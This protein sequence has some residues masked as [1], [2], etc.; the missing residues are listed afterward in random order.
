M[1]LLRVADRPDRVE[2]FVEVA[3]SGGCAQHVARREREEHLHRVLPFRSIVELR[4]ELQFHHYVGIDPEHQHRRRGDAEVANVEAVLLHVPRASARSAFPP[5]PFPEAVAEH[6]GIRSIRRVRTARRTD[7][8]HRVEIQRDQ[9]MSACVD[10]AQ[11]FGV[12]EPVPRRSRSSAISRGR[13]CVL[14]RLE[15][16]VADGG[17]DPPDDADRAERDRPDRR[18]RLD[19]HRGTVR[20]DAEALH[21]LHLRGPATGTWARDVGRR[22]PPTAMRR[23]RARRRSRWP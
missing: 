11:E 18:A 2:Q 13:A 7:G 23:H 8:R 10:P 14:A 16:A 5:P 9:G 22:L 15:R 12:V 21:A 4:L 20:R 6:R 1:E 3:A 17:L 19:E